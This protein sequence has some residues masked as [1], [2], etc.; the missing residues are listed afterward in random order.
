MPS[1]LVIVID[2]EGWGVA[3]V[4][5]VLSS[6]LGSGNPA[7]PVTVAVF[8]SGERAFAA[9]LAVIVKVA[10]PPSGRLDSVALMSPEPLAG[11]AAPPAYD[12]VQVAPKSPAGSVSATIVLLTL[13]GPRLLTTSL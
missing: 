11:P 6:G 8:D 3:I 9:T 2:V 5:E 10:V 1:V 4:V 7:G 12:T 13:L